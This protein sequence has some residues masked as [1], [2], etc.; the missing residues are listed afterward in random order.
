MNA[1]AYLQ[2]I[3]S[4][5]QAALDAARKGLDV[6]VPTTPGWTVG[7]VI[8]HL[9]Q[10]HRQKTHIVREL[11]VDGEP[12]F[13]DFAPPPGA[14]LLEWFEEGLH[15]LAE[16]LSVADPATPVHTWHQPDQTIGFWI[17]RMAHETL[18]HRVDAELGH[19]HNTPVDPFLGA[20]GVDEIL[21]VFMGGYPAWA[22]VA[23]SEVR[24]GLE[25]EDR[26]WTV[27]FGSWS[28]TS[29]NSRRKFRDVPGLE[30]VAGDNRPAAV[31]RGPGDVLDLFMW[32]RGSA[33]GLI[34]EGHPSVLLYLRD[35][36]AD[37]TG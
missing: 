3:R 34:I 17:R 29:P 35:V 31:V 10:V 33:D 14:E 27:R 21:D 37:A 20:D 13:S 15:E 16:V 19:G 6:P 9:G 24:V 18:I 36:A 1:G 28:G 32:G 4:D 5:G 26:S 12:A 11:L 30:L 25:S 22:A 23:R 8:A 2:A 7:D